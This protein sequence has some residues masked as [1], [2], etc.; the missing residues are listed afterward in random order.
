MAIETMNCY[1]FLSHFHRIGSHTSRTRKA[2]RQFM[3][4]RHSLKEIN[5]SRWPCACVVIVVV[6]MVMVMVVFFFSLKQN[7]TKIK[8][9]KSKAINRN[10]S[11][12][13]S[14]ASQAS[15][16]YPLSY[17][18]CTRYLNE[19][20]LICIFCATESF[21]ENCVWW[22]IARWRDQ[23]K[24][25]IFN[26]VSAPTS[27]YRTMRFKRK[28]VFRCNFSKSTEEIFQAHFIIENSSCCGPFFHH[29]N[30]MYRIGSAQDPFPHFC[31]HS[32]FRMLFPLPYNP[33]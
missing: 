11:H 30:Q 2:S 32:L 17:W 13:N 20:K 18:I 8:M 4:K 28:H 21:T 27:V 25:H 26:F 16:I 29:R 3:V 23:M 33:Y 1:R 24:I 22:K 19:N 15:N 7:K 14:F 31:Q 5:S 10:C 12:V 9:N 6:V